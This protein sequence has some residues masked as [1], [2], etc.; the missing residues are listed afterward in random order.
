M[1]WFHHDPFSHRMSNRIQYQQHGLTFFLKFEWACPHT[2]VTPITNRHTTL[3]PI[4]YD[5]LV[6]S[7]GPLVAC[8][9]LQNALRP[10]Y[11]PCL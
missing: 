1:G 8:T 5:T 2:L 6:A 4:S 11:L 3:I 10:V 9:H 7:K